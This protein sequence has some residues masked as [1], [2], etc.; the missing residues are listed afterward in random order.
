MENSSKN[1][2]RNFPPDMFMLSGIP[3][4]GIALVASAIFSLG[5]NHPLIVLSSALIVATMGAS[6]LFWAK[7][8]LYQ[9]HIFLSFGPR[10]IPDSHRAF[11]Y[12][13]IGLAAIGC[14]VAGLMLYG[15]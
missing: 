9:Q 14:S 10:V 11:Y 2:L 5:A 6:L 8:P 4:G 13:G 7:I 12:W 15:I 3:I 1:S